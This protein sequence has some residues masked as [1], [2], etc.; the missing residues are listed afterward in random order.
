LTKIE[1]ATKILRVSEKEDLDDNDY[2]NCEGVLCFECPA[3]RVDL[4]TPHNGCKMRWFRDYYYDKVVEP[5]ERKRDDSKR[6]N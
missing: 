1:V 6:S 5:L 3:Y 4:P 2:V